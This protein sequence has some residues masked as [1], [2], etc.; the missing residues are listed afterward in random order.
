MTTPPDRENSTPESQEDPG[1]LET[2]EEVAKGLVRLWRRFMKFAKSAPAILTM[3]TLFA[4]GTG[5]LGDHVL[6]SLRSDSNPPYPIGAIG[7][8]KP[9]IKAGDP[10]MS[11]GIIEN[12]TIDGFSTDTDT[13]G[14]VNP[15]RTSNPKT[16]RLVQVE[17]PA[18]A[19]GSCDS[20]CTTAIHNLL[21]G[22]KLSD[23]HNSTCTATFKNVDQGA[24]E[25]E[26]G[27]DNSGTLAGHLLKY[28]NDGEKVT[29]VFSGRRVEGI[30]DYPNILFANPSRG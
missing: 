24:G 2:V 12:V 3:G 17:F 9:N 30:T 21:G 22:D 8:G 18:P 10:S 19:V 25:K 29:I 27:K 6:V 7:I 13:I 28:K 23:C 5:G 14:G 11:M 20:Y 26:G 16:R 1:V 15:D 4:F